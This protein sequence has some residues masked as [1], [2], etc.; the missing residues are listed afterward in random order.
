MRYL[1]NLGSRIQSLQI[2]VM[3]RRQMF[4]TVIPLKKTL[5]LV[6]PWMMD[7]TKITNYQTWS[8]KEVIRYPS[9]SSQNQ[10]MMALDLKARWTNLILI[11]R[12]QILQMKILLK[13]IWKTMK[14]ILKL[15][16]AKKLIAC[17]HTEIGNKRSI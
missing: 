3:M 9:N 12:T 11:R 1:V 17:K 8:I 6:T 2:R 13:T 7:L 5:L 10:K 15:Q 14:L 16:T 4:Q